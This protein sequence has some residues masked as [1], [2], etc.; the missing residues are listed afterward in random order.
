MLSTST[1]LIL[2]LHLLLSHFIALNFAM[3]SFSSPCP[4]FFYV[5]S[6]PHSFITSPLLFPFFPNLHCFKSIFS[7]FSLSF[8]IFPK[9]LPSLPPA[10]YLYHLHSFIISSLLF[11][12]FF[13]QHRHF[14]PFPL[15]LPSTPASAAPHAWVTLTLGASSPD[16]RNLA[17]GSPLPCSSSKLNSPD[18]E[19][20]KMH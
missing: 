16:P 3:S 15:P 14:L 4:L 20:E 7:F 19:R 9:V 6:F 2:L 12:P 8:I 17:E 13:P 5:P 18:E 1:I 10:V 11:L